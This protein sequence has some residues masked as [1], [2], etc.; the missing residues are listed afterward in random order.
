MLTGLTFP[1]EN[2][3]GPTSS[4]NSCY[5]PEPTGVLHALGLF[6]DGLSGFVLKFKL[7][8]FQKED[9]V[10]HSVIHSSSQGIHFEDQ[11]RRIS[12]EHIHY[13]DV[14]D[15]FEN[16]QCANNCC[17]KI[18]LSLPVVIPS[19]LALLTKAEWHSEHLFLPFH[20]ICVDETWGRRLG[21]Y[22]RPITD[23]VFV[24]FCF[25]AVWESCFLIH[26]CD[27]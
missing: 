9:I 26:V 3:V 20:T 27:E 8:T 4:P 18:R 14:N 5:G 17:L 10:W 22:W 2:V 1:R 12:N 25:S 19:W 15:C 21:M 13:L 23:F 24:L 7:E 6:E 11:V 16:T